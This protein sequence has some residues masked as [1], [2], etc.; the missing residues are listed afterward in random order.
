LSCFSF[1]GKI[2]SVVNEKAGTRNFGEQIAKK[3]IYSQRSNEM[4]RI[5]Q[6]SSNPGRNLIRDSN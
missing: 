6:Q 5:E 2:K 1:E 3:F 4:A